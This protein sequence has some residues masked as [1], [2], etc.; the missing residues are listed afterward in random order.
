MDL[1]EDP[2]VLA[3][4]RTFGASVGDL[5]GHGGEARV[6]ALGDDRVLRILHAGGRAEDIGRRQ[7]LVDELSR[8]RPA[9]ALPQ[10]LDV[11]E[12]A[13]RV[14]AIERR[15]PGRSVLGALK[16]CTGNE[17]RQLVERHLD[18]AAALGDLHLDQRHVFGDLVCDD[19]ITT[20]T[21]RA[22][23]AERAAANLARS[24]SDFWSIDSERLADELPEATGP[25]FVHLD[26][27]VGNML[28]DG[29]RITAV[30]DIGSTSVAGDRRLDPLSAAVYLAAPEITPVATPADIDVAM[31]WLRAV[32]LQEWFDP[33]RRWLAAF[34]SFAVDD[35]NVLRWC[36]RILLDHR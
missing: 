16:S 1:P 4:L 3:V 6:Y 9:F 14:F 20:S 22:Y 29:T 24:V 11:G 27:F 23:L 17:R 28:T 30:I 33:A 31:S 36:R 18:T 35:P 21:W 12:T 10:V 19:P 2:A 5:L 15:L 13:G 8:A 32:D 26:A 25:A 34:W 7:H